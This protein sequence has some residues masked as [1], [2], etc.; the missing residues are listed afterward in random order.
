[1]GNNRKGLSL[2]SAL[3]ACN[4]CGTPKHALYWPEKRPLLTPSSVTAPNGGLQ[5]GKKTGD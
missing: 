1:M 5:M 3:H 2:Q 4:S